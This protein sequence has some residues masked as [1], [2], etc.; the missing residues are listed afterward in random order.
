MQFAI[1]DESKEELTIITEHGLFCYKKLP[2]GVASSPAEC[3]EILEDVLRGIPNTKIYIDNI[4]CTG[5]TREEHIQILNEIFSRLEKAGLKVNLNKCDFF[6]KEIEILGFLIDETGLK[7]TISKIKAV[8]E[9]PI[10][11][12]Q[13]E[14]KAFL[15][16][17][18]YY[19][20]FLPDRAEHAKSLYDLSNAKNFVW[21]DECDKAYTWMKEQITSDRVL[22]LFDENEEM[23]LACDASQYGLSAVLSHRFKD[24]TERPIAFASKIIPKSELHRAIL[25]KE[26]GAIVF[27]FKKFYQYVWGK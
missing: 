13:K 14:L 22:V 16:L 24:G 25:D 3:Q 1:D 17:V 2:E 12:N 5:K 9:A 26:A 23:V 18:N 20:R 4:Y 19:E 7:P 10:P 6:K 8:Q 11:K 15:G 21:T 27:G